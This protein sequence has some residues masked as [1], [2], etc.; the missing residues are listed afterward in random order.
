M[1]I[2]LGGL[3]ETHQELRPRHVITTEEVQ[4]PLSTEG[5]SVYLFIYLQNSPCTAGWLTTEHRLH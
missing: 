2:I 3:I 4:E 5:V 1:L